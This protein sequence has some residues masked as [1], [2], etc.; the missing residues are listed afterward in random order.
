MVKA[1]EFLAIAV[2]IGQPLFG[3]FLSVRDGGLLL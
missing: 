1:P 2:P 3:A